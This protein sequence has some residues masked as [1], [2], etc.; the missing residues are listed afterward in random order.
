MA[1]KIALKLGYESPFT[2]YS[3]FSIQKDYRLAWLLNQALGFELERIGDFTHYFSET[4]P[5]AFSLFSYHYQQYRMQVF[6]LSNKSPEGPILSESP[7]PD[8]LLL[9][10]NLSEIFDLGQFQK[11]LRKIS[12]VQ[13]IIEVSEKTQ[14]KHEAFFYDLEY[15]LSEKKII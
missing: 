12:Q 2:V 13:T 6:L 3:V 7:V 15:F 10:W 5:A 14:R 8:F 4:R 1:K 11:D 9:F